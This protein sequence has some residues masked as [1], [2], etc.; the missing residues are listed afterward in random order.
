MVSVKIQCPCG[1]R[2]AFDVEP[3][4]GIMPSP[5]A[6]PACGADGT[7][8]ANDC[9]SRQHSVV[10]EA[11]AASSPSAPAATA[12]PESSI[13]LTPR[14]TAR[15]TA[16][17]PDT[18]LGLVSRTQ[19]EHEARSKVTWG[20][21]PEQVTGYLMV[22]GFSYEEASDLAKKLFKERASSIRA[23]GIRKIMT[24]FGLLCVPVIALLVFI[25]FRVI[26]LTLFAMTVAVGI[27]G[28]YLIIKGILMAVAPKSEKGDVADQ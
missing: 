22:Q 7:A 13:R 9:I 28:A 27:F 24:G 23:N 3:V 21:S 6:C 20:D 18:R 2:Y 5:I 15:P 10:A 26:P 1:Q 16:T 17:N 14:P 4:N 19:A 8:S 25:C 12:A 11:V